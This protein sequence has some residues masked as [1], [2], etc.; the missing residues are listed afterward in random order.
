MEKRQLRPFGLAPSGTVV[1]EAI[2]PADAAVGDTVTAVPCVR[3][4]E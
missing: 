3:R 2:A 4:R 1:V